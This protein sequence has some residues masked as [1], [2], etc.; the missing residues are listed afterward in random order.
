VVVDL[1]ANT[2]P[3]QN[4]ALSLFEEEVMI[5]ITCTQSVKKSVRSVRSN[6]NSL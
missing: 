2:K 1:L 5:Y 6:L 4:T 3:K